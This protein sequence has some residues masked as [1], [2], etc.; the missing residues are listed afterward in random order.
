MVKSAGSFALRGIIDRDYLKKLKIVEG[1]SAELDKAR[2]SPGDAKSSAERREKAYPWP[3]EKKRKTIMEEINKDVHG[4]LRPRK[5]KKDDIEKALELLDGSLDYEPENPQTLCNYALAHIRMSHFEPQSEYLK[6]AL[7]YAEKCLQ[8]R[9]KF[10]RGYFLTAW[11]LYRQGEYD[12]AFDINAQGLEKNPNHRDLLHQRIKML[13]DLKRYGEAIPLCKRHLR[14][15]PDDR[16]VYHFLW[17]CQHKLGMSRDAKETCKRV[18]AMGK[19]RE[20]REWLKR[21]KGTAE[22]K[23]SSVRTSPGDAEPPGDIQAFPGLI[24]NSPETIKI[25]ASVS[26]TSI[27]NGTLK[28]SAVESLMGQLMEKGK[29]KKE[30]MRI[31]ENFKTS[32]SEWRDEQI[33][34]QHGLPD[35]KKDI[36]LFEGPLYGFNYRRSGIAMN[37]KLFDGS[38]NLTEKQL[39]WLRIWV[40]MHDEWD[41]MRRFRE[42]T[43]IGKLSKAFASWH[44]NIRRCLTRAFEKTEHHG[45][46]I[47]SRYLHALQRNLEHPTYDTTPYVAALTDFDLALSFDL[48]EKIREGLLEE[49][50]AVHIDYMGI[51]NRYREYGDMVNET[52]YKANIS[53]LS[54]VVISHLLIKLKLKLTR[55]I[56]DIENI[57]R[58][59]A[60]V[61]KVSGFQT[62]ADDIIRYKDRNLQEGMLRKIL[63]LHYYIRRMPKP[64][65]FGRAELKALGVNVLDDKKRLISVIDGVIH[66]RGST[67]GRRHGYAWVNISKN[68]RNFESKLE[69]MIR[70]YFRLTESDYI[71]PIDTLPAFKSEAGNVRK[72][73]QIV[74]ITS[75]NKVKSENKKQIEER[76]RDEFKKVVNEYLDKMPDDVA[77][78]HRYLKRISVQ[79]VLV[80]EL[81]QRDTSDRVGRSHS[82]GIYRKSIRTIL[83]IV[84]VGLLAYLALS[85]IDSLVGHSS[86]LLGTGATSIPVKELAMVAFF[87][88]IEDISRKRTWERKPHY[89]K[90]LKKYRAGLRSY[91]PGHRRIAAYWF[92]YMQEDGLKELKDVLFDEK[93][94]EGMKRDAGYGL[95]SMRGQM[96]KLALK[97]LEKGF[98]HTN[99]SVSRA[100]LH[101]LLLM[102]GTIA[103]E[104][105]IEFLNSAGKDPG[106]GYIFEEVAKTYQQLP[107]KDKGRV[108]DKFDR[109][110]KGLTGNAKQKFQNVYKQDRSSTGF[111]IG[112][113]LIGVLVALGTTAVIAFAMA[114]GAWWV[115]GAGII[116]LF[117]IVGVLMWRYLSRI[118]E[119]LV[120]LSYHFRIDSVIRSYKKAVLLMP[121]ESKYSTGPGEEK[122]EV[123]GPDH[124]DYEKNQRR[125]KKIKKAIEILREKGFGERADRLEEVTTILGLTNMKTY[126]LYSD[127]KRGIFRAFSPGRRRNVLYS[128]IKFLDNLRLDRPQDME[129]LASL[130]NQ[131]QRFLD[132]YNSL[133]ERN[134]PPREMHILLKESQNEIYIWAS[135]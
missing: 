86:R 69:R 37:I 115:F 35:S 45:I 96:K 93:T 113:R 22:E 27:S 17:A 14:M 53:N 108:R 122:P 105:L 99:E 46:P 15:H 23:K 47:N 10:L 84:A 2:T 25:W 42:E 68:P 127:R 8:V 82:G 64:K 9:P 101:S 63:Y 103:D 92:S 87:G 98:H 78:K 89:L 54:K 33:R 24:K 109:I 131:Q 12:K 121:K 57:I 111:A 29:S 18:L 13:V 65:G 67:H 4:I 71:H 32:L 26:R 36:L 81:V 90:N 75:K 132:T 3:A 40:R 104:T 48:R 72:L 118:K 61:E 73:A 123:I 88:G 34:T 7:S 119:D 76:L 38:L 41:V 125:I 110:S 30:A 106:K 20:K 102:K 56:E 11:I 58:A 77:K 62:F 94:T 97:V 19:W 83:I 116:G 95:R 28:H 129:I 31:V 6:K 91:I 100:S 55:G 60:F 133:S 39:K 124:A 130:L 21:L 50:Y 43:I 134:V 135:S 85:G 79:L 120:A 126:L 80:P 114:K 49:A 59:F 128:S 1:L 16:P 51:R 112:I 70:A 5:C 44:P 117:A 52:L 66:I 107:G 74:F